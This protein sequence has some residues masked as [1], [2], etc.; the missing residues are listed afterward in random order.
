MAQAISPERLVGLRPVPRGVNSD[1]LAFVVVLAFAIAVLAIPIG[2]APIWAGNDARWV[3]LARDVVE[4]GRWLMPEIR[5]LPNEGLYKPQ[6]FTWS[7]ALASL[8]SGH[9]TE[10]TAALPSAVSA[11]AAVGGIVAIGSLLW[12]CLLY[13]SP[14]PRDGLLSRMPSSA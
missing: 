12:G 6:L 5:G 8:T 7:I 4:H 14:S 10:F 2:R 13:T 1:R 11:L 9:V 3:L